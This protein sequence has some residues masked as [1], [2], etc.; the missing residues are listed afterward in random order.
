MVG[1]EI[2]LT[3][4]TTLTGEPL[5]KPRQRASGF[6][7]AAARCLNIPRGP[8]ASTGSPMRLDERRQAPKRTS[9]ASQ[10]SQG[11]HGV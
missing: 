8:H 10:V 11:G 2:S 6:P 7:G 9:G 5:G 4:L 1:I 3:T